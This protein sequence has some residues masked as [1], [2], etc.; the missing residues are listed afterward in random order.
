MIDRLIESAS[1]GLDVWLDILSLKIVSFFFII[2]I[3]I[4]IFIIILII[5]WVTGVIKK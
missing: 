5:H 2:L 4:I 1:R 3:I